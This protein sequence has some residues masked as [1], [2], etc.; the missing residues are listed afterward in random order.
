MDILKPEL[1]LLCKS[2]GLKTTG[3]KTE[4]ISY[5]IQK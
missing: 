1:V 2:K 4:L 5:L 3:T